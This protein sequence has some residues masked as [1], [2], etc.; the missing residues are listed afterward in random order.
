[1]R[2]ISLSLAW[3]AG[4]YIGSLVSLPL[5]AFLVA[6]IP[7]LI[8][9]LLWHKRP[10]FLWGGLCLIVLF[11]A[12]GCYQWR[13]SEPTLQPFNDQGRVEIKGEVDRDPEFEGAT[14]RLSLSAQEIKIDSRWEKVSGKVLIYTTV[15]PSYGQ[16]DLLQVT[17]ELHSLSQ[18]ENEAYLT[19]QGFSSTMSYPQIDFI[20][21]GWLFSLR[22]R[23]AES[24]DSALPKPQ[25]SLAQALLLGIRSHIPDS[26]MKAFRDTGT[27]HLIAISGLHV[28]ILGGIVLSTAAWVFGRRRPTYI[29][30]VFGIIWL[31]VLLTGMRPPA[32]RAAI[33]FSLLLTALW[34]GRPQSALPS[35]ALA[36]AIMV[37]IS[38]LVLWDVSFQL[39]FVAMAGLI[40]LFPAFQRWGRKVMA[41]E[42]EALTS[43]AN[44]IIDSFAVT[45]AA[46]IATLPLIAYYF[47]YVSLVAL[48]ATFLALLALPGAIV[49]AL[50]T[51]FLG[52]FA[53]PL[54]WAIGWVDWLFLSYIIK[55]VEGFGA[56]PFAKYELTISGIMVWVYYGIIVAILSRKRWGMALSK[57][58]AWVQERLGKLPQLAFRVPKRAILVLL[59]VATALVW[60]AVIATP[61]RQLEVSFLDV[62]Q[63]DAI[64]IQTPSH[65][66]ILI[67]G[68]PDPE[69]MSLWLGKKLPF[70]DKSLDLVVLT[71]PEND[72]LVG[73]VEVLHSYKVGQV[74]EPGFKHDIPAYEEWLRLIDEKDIKRTIAKAGQQIELGDG[75]R[76]EVLHPQEEFLEGT[77]SDTNNNSVVLRLVWKEVSFLLTGDICEE[78]EREILYRGYKLSSTVLKVAHH[79]SAT[80]T[81][82]QFLAAVDPQV[83]VISVGENNLFGHPDEETMDRLGERLSEDKIY[84]T[85]QHGTITFTTDGQRLWVEVEEAIGGFHPLYEAEQV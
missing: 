50:L 74:L 63:G 16:G 65:Q 47:G 17:G 42:K 14:S 44:P 23:L 19:K 51:A 31:Y 37:G 85:S 76:I 18:I 57:P 33:M 28:A 29:L 73:L 5:Y 40:L 8:V 7:S 84:L 48:P 21:T 64:L 54:S 12:I 58:I 39:S 3:V 61:D 52:L 24:L 56:L 62:G 26:L 60:L 69:A 2:L 75:I 55:V 78:A 1:M 83:A 66:Q 30:I 46:V 32:L 22:N 25:S 53:P 59:L 80:S 67:D 43:A 41:G 45:L 9:A 70:Y 79:G 71:H 38:P 11:S 13:V 72:H 36:A 81:S 35:L 6:F 68:G 15:F 20:Q 49:L 4:I 34:L 77:D 82:G 10:A 27:A